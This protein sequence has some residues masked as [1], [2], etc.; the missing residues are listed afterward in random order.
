MAGVLISETFVDKFE[1]DDTQTGLIV[2]LF[3]VGAFGGAMFAGSAFLTSRLASITDDVN[4]VQRAIILV[5]E[6]H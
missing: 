4:L 2:A 6:A 3:T 1:A 5:E